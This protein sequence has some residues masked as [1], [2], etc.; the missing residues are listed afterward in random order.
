M[1]SDHLLI[2]LHV[3]KIKNGAIL[4][5]VAKVGK[6]KNCHIIMITDFVTVQTNVLLDNNFYFFVMM[7]TGFNVD[8]FGGIRST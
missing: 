8:K 6:Q 3:W 2:T 5:P 1:T 7:W 4:L